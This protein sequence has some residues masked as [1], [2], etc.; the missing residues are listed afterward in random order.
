MNIKL[1]K[2]E[3][4]EVDRKM[5]ELIKNHFDLVVPKP[6]AC[7]WCGWPTKYKSTAYGDMQRCTNPECRHEEEDNS[8][9]DEENL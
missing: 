2:E 7:T 8:E 9:L 1:T 5:E 6:F 4:K 3:L